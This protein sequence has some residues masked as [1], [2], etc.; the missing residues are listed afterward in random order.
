MTATEEKKD[1]SQS[2]TSTGAKFWHHPE[3]LEGLRNGKPRCVTSHIMLTDTCQ[4]SCAM[5][6]VQTREGNALLPEVVIRY[7]EQLLP[8]GLK[9]VIL[10]G[11]GN[12][13]L[14]THKSKDYG[15]RDWD[16]NDVVS[17]LHSKGLQIG[18]ITNG[19]P[20]K[21]GWS[22]REYFGDTLSEEAHR[23]VEPQL[24]KERRSWKTV[25]PSTL[26]KLTWIRVSMSGLDHEENEVF[27]PDVDP[28]KTTLGFSYVYH[29]IYEAPNEENHGKVSTPE[30]L[31]T[32]GGGNGVV[33]LAE[34]RFATLTSQITELV[35]Q[36][37]PKYVRLLP[38]CL[39]PPKIAARCKR[40]QEMA[41]AINEQC[42]FQSAFVQYKPPEAP[43]ACWL[44]YLHPVLNSDGFVYPCDSCVLNRAAGHKFAEPWRI[45]HWSKIGEIYSQPARTLIKEPG[46]QCPSCVFTKSNLLLQSVVD[47]APLLSAQTVDH[48]NFI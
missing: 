14:Y 16:F 30:D 36:H 29:D 45:C 31:E 35:A 26:D 24:L 48:P 12:P 32:Y 7:V 33:R 19:M 25:Y 17:F 3:A 38:N 46:K 40:L 28:T 43:P 20:M 44:G 42:G 41:D 5:C 2:F 37:K 15:D 10:S 18:V 39:E 6:S 34:D 47:G 23:F 27:V 8:F 4:H 9:S 22:S 11:G 1:L 21:T 13:I